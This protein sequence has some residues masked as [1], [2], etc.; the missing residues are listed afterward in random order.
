MVYPPNGILIRT[1]RKKPLA[2]ATAWVY[3]N[4]VTLNERRQTQKAMYCVSPFVGHSGKGK[5]VGKEN[6]GA[7]A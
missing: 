1:K 4:C 3:L 5:T 2:H 6:R 7:G